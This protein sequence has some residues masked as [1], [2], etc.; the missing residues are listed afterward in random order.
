[1]LAD[2]AAEKVT[3]GACLSSP[4]A[5]AE[6]LEIL[7]PD[8]FHRP[9]HQIIFGAQLG[10]KA[11]QLP[12]DPVAVA[13]LL[14]R[15]GEISRIGG[16]P[17]LHDLI[18]S[19]PVAANAAYY[20][21]IVREMSV[22]RHIA[23]AGERMAQ[24]A[25]QLGDDVA[26]ILSGAEQDIAAVAAEQDGD[27]LD[28]MDVAAFARAE[29]P[30]GAPVI[31][32]LLHEQ[33]RVVVVAGEGSGKT[34]LAMQCGIMTAAG[35]HLFTAHYT[36]PARSL[37]VDLENPSANVQRRARRLTA[38]AETVRDWDP[39]RC[40]IWSRPA[41][42]DLREAPD[43]RR[44]MSVIARTEPRLIIAGPVYKMSV[45]RGERAE[46]L[47]SSVTTFWDRV[48]ER[49]GAAIWLEAHAPMS[50]GGRRDLRPVGSGIYLRWPEFGISLTPSKEEGDD[51]GTLLLS[52]FRGHREDRVWPV[53][54]VRSQPWSWHGVYAGEWR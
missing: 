42:L 23:A 3:L 6:C 46:Q 12:A 43:Q 32:G 40:H 20:A 7:R 1:M 35:L 54:I 45:D 9:A 39:D 19:V 4:A 29:L 48:R 34:E 17:Y 22:R 37:I 51:A 14:V 5:L 47:H 30:Y 16:A 50:Q 52:G 21:R 10:L 11:A 25:V 13:D 31:P 49:T 38:Y 8:D 36:D 15:S 44:L 2:L 53:K 27:G 26:S 33:E 24:R 28:A 18:A 41:G